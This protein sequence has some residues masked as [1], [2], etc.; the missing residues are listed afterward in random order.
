MRRNPARFEAYA[1]G[2]LR[3]WLA[4]NAA[5][6]DAVIAGA[7]AYAKPE[8]RMTVPVKFDAPALRHLNIE[9]VQDFRE[10][11]ILQ[12]EA[13]KRAIITRYGR[14]RIEAAGT[15]GTD[16]AVSQAKAT[17]IAQGGPWRIEA[18][19]PRQP[20]LSRVAYIDLDGTGRKMW[21]AMP[22]AS[23]A[24]R[25]T[26]EAAA[27]QK[28]G[29]P[30]GSAPSDPAIYFVTHKGVENT[31]Y[32]GFL[33]SDTTDWERVGDARPTR[34]AEAA[35]T[36]DRR[37]LSPG[38]ERALD[39]MVLYVLPDP[40]GSRYALTA[41]DVVSELTE[42]RANVFRQMLADGK[43]GSY[44]WETAFTATGDD[45]ALLDAAEYRKQVQTR[46][47]EASLRR[48]V[49]AEW[50]QE[51]YNSRQKANGFT[52]GKHGLSSRE[53]E[54]ALRSGGSGSPAKAAARD[55]EKRLE[56]ENQN[57]YQ[58][59]EYKALQAAKDAVSR[60]SA[61]VAHPFATR[62][63]VPALVAAV[64]RLTTLVRELS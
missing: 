33:Q 10:G 38:A 52:K 54:T 20:R 26:K 29:Y 53:R 64:E 44:P 39:T 41:A 61:T 7:L 28:A 6:V 22:S 49:K 57:Y 18:Y 35:K 9:Q 56:R 62:A 21:V 51:A 5:R 15:H 23:E 32:Q 45:A 25:Y 16:R 2:P 24:A 59:P 19:A 17:E 42:N 12:D 27:W 50:A 14:A 37:K 8:S 4:V 46:L 36:A 55:V 11:T 13:G 34:R 40:E 60:A 63:D 31:I 30:S 43:A 47:I 48:L 3:A 58:L 1:S